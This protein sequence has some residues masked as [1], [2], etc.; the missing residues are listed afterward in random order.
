[1]DNQKVQVKGGKYSGKSWFCG[2]HY[3]ITETEVD[4][5]DDSV[6]LLQ[7]SGFAKA[8][9]KIRTDIRYNDI[10][11]VSSRRKYS[12]PNVLLGTI[13]AILGLI[14]GAYVIITVLFVIWLGRT[15]VVKISYAGTEYTIPTEFLNEAHD[16]ETKINAAIAQSRA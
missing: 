4:F 3:K 13:C 1:M 15:A 14:T 5:N 10:T 9:N 16:L 8:K 7:G 6:S 2:Q 12:I 11:S